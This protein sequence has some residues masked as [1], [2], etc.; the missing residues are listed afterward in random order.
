MPLDP[1]IA[2]L[3]GN[4]V[5]PSFRSLGVEQLRTIMDGSTD[6]MPKL[7]VPRA[8]VHDRALASRTGDIPLRIYTPQGK[9]PFSLL[10]YCHGGGFFAGHLDIADAICRAL[11]HGAAC[12]V[13]SVD[14]RLAPEH[15][16]PAATDDAYAVL[17]WAA[18]HA[19]ELDVDARRIAVG[20]DSA[21]GNLATVSALRA[22]DD[23]GPRLCAQLLLYPGTRYPDPELFPSLREHAHAP[24]LSA[25]DSYFCWEQYLRT[26]DDRQHPYAAPAY[27]NHRGLP[28]ALVA[29]AELDPGRDGAAAY[30][31][32]LQAA[33]VPTVLRC[34]TGMP[35]GFFSWVG[36]STRARTAMDE[37]CDWLKQQFASV[38]T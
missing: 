29:T 3:L 8:A 18:V 11:C 19:D 15:K 7:D 2:A 12:V 16:F 17:Q 10:V 26:D 35:H 6:M 25:D 32:Q 36:L 20:G 13:V 30:A 28:P 14:Y 23:G 4:V 34:Y 24:L 22:R 1:E 38:R 33:D 21:G 31:E 5:M 37:T 9:G 27:A